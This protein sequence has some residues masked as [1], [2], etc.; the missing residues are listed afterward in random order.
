MHGTPICDCGCC[1]HGCRDCDPDCMSREAQLVED[2]GPPSDYWEARAP[3][4]AA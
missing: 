4:H 1:R 3:R 2:D